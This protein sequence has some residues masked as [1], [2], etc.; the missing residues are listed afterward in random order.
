MFS[1]IE[2]ILPTD[3]RNQCSE[4]ESNNC[5]YVFW[6]YFVCKK[7]RAEKTRKMLLWKQRK[8][9][10]LR[11]KKI[12]LSL[13]LNFSIFFDVIGLKSCLMNC[14]VNRTHVSL[15]VSVTAIPAWRSEEGSIQYCLNFWIR[16][17]NLHF[18]ENLFHQT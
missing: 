7:S 4:R 6:T 16:F 18:L 1:R 14:R 10:K 5:K 3:I 15:F 2:T 12:W 13:F 11:R 17:V 9:K 8:W